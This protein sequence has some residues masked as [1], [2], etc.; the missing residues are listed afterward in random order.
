MAGSYADF[1]LLKIVVIESSTRE[2]LLAIIND[3]DTERQKLHAGWETAS[4]NEAA[5]E[6]KVNRMESRLAEAADT[7]AWL[8][9]IH[10]TPQAKANW[11]AGG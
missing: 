6:E 7:M 9:S 5:W 10:P 8:G 2:D 1:E 4:D 11:I 3:L